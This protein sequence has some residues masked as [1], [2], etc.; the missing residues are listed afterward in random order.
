MRRFLQ[1]LGLPGG[2]PGETGDGSTPDIAENLA[3]RRRE[4]WVAARRNHGTADLSSP[5]AKRRAF[6]LED[7]I[8]AGKEVPAETLGELLNDSD[9]GVRIL[10]RLA[11]EGPTLRWPE[12]ASPHAAAAVLR[13]IATREA[14]LQGKGGWARLLRGIYRSVKD[15]ALQLHILEILLNVV[16][17]VDDLDAPVV[18]GTA[19]EGLDHSDRKIRCLSCDILGQICAPVFLARVAKTLED[20]D[21][22][23]RRRAGAA[24]VRYGDDALQELR[25]RLT[26]SRDEVV[27]GIVQT[28]GSI[29]TPAAH[30]LLLENLETDFRQL[31]WLVDGGRNL[32]SDDLWHLVVEDYERRAFRH[33]L[34]VLE[35]LGHGDVVALIRRDSRQGVCER[36]TIDALTSLHAGCFLRPIVNLLE[37]QQPT[38]PLDAGRRRL[39][40][41]LGLRDRWLVAG[42]LVCR[43]QSPPADLAMHA[44]S[45]V[46]RTVTE[47][48]NRQLS[49]H[50]LYRLLLLKKTPAYTSLSLDDLVVL[51]DSLTL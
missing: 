27:E 44:D 10:A 30:H 29:G 40:E 26:S 41:A 49:D 48:E 47:L 36:D 9:E 20:L 13:V 15:P 14:G 17:N 33:I 39:D 37:D 45:L 38:R 32:V 21:P 18:A 3:N 11:S 31:G 4:T 35:A 1:R 5:A 51:D 23:V 28:T 22:E 34:R 8:S 46:R 16:H 2:S 50:F 6:A 24:L 7:L 19:L 25:R 42:A 12:D 43:H